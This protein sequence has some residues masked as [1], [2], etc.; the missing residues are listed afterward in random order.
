MLR[1]DGRTISDREGSDKGISAISVASTHAQAKD[2]H[3]RAAPN[4]KFEIRNYS[5]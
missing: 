1:T 2:E 5:S 3:R 4:L